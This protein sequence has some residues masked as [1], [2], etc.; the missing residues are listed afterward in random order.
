MI[1]QRSIA[2]TTILTIS[3]ILAPGCS[4][5][6][7]PT[8]PDE[9]DGATSAATSPPAEP[10]TEGRALL[11]AW[12]VEFDF[13]TQEVTLEPL[14]TAATHFSIL[15]LLQDPWFCPGG[16][17]LTINFI[18]FDPVAGYF[19]IKATLANPSTIV[20]HDVRGIVYDNDLTNHQVLN[21]DDYT[22]LWAPPDYDSVYP[23]RAYAKADPDRAFKPLASYSELY[24]FQFDSLPPKWNFV[25]AVDCSWP[26]NCE[27]PFEIVNQ[28]QT[29]N[30][31]AAHGCSLLTVQVH[32]HGGPAHVKGVT[33]DTSSLAGNLVDMEYNITDDTWETLIMN[34]TPVSAGVRD[35]LITASSPGTDLKLY[36]YFTID[37]LSIA[38]EKIQGTI[39]GSDTGEGI[40][41][42]LMTTSDGDNLYMADAD[43]CGF[44]ATSDVPDGSR[45]L[46]FTKPGYHS[47]HVLTVV[48]GD[49]II[50]EEFLEPFLD[51]QPE[52]PEITLNEP[53]VDIINGMVGI[54]G[55]MLNMDC[56]G[57]QVGVYVHQGEEHLMGV[58]NYTGEFHQIVF[59]AYGVNEIVVRATNATGTVLSDKII[60]EYYPAWDFR[61]TLTWDT[62]DSD[63]DIHVWEQDLFNHCYYSNTT[64]PHLGLDI[65]ILYG[66]GPE[67]ITP[68]TDELPEGVYPIAVNY[69]ADHDDD[70]YEDQ[71]TTNFVT[72]RLNPG[73]PFEEIVIFDYLLTFENFNSD[74]PVQY[75][76][77]SWWRPCDLVV[78]DTGIVTWQE[79]DFSFQLFL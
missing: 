45:V 9:P 73:T 70:F 77:A 27:E 13:E 48:G 11:M 67:N 16:Y 10:S 78:H 69:Y 31:Y 4:G 33:L 63:M 59:L 74:Y 21:A 30:Y 76:T 8:S 61:I 19:L 12:E 42:A 58:D 46:S 1:S 7:S 29:G 6:G 53:A 22:D 50:I 60:I 41:L 52:M 55:Y 75:S 44:L 5:T 36:D 43:F 37:A 72:L 32:H 20:A 34:D 23:F 40:P 35:L 14:R 47:A 15:E 26:S 64:T 68:I 79:P 3:F 51:D 2:L 65:D 71:P 39:Y 49:D 18:E 62:D 38:D 17:C 66:F 54:S 28:T 57:N 25:Y 56:F 24:E